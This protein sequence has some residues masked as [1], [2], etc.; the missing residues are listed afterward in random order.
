MN[1]EFRD[2]YRKYREARTKCPFRVGDI[3]TFC[4][5]RGNEICRFIVVKTRDARI[6]QIR[7]IRDYNGKACNWMQ[8]AFY[9]WDAGQFRKVDDFAQ[10]MSIPEAPPVR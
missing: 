9:G 5:G 4:P 3:L 1:R 6:T 10:D 2:I 8:Y 7:V